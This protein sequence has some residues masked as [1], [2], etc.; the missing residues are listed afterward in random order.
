MLNVF[1]GDTGSGSLKG[2]VP[3]TISGD[4]VKYLK[5]DGTWGISGSTFG[6][7]TVTGPTHLLMV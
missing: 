5:G 1:V 6:G 7:G 3:A 2:L 4:G